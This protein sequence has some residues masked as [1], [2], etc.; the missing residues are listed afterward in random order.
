MNCFPST[1]KKNLTT[2]IS[3]IVKGRN[4]DFLFGMHFS[5]SG[6]MLIHEE[7]KGSCA[8]IKSPL[9]VQYLIKY[10]D[11]NYKNNPLC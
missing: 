1:P 3:R 7:Q 4:N 6:G 9:Y 8:F 10:R 2:L 11:K 5:A